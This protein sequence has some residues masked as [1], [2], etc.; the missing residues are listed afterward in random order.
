MKYEQSEGTHQGQECQPETA[1][2]GE[3]A[4]SQETYLRT[5]I[6]FRPKHEGIRSQGRAGRPHVFH[7]FSNTEKGAKTRGA[8]MDRAQAKVWRA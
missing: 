2:T 6:Q 7:R 3:P 8:R 5:L 4:A 1:T